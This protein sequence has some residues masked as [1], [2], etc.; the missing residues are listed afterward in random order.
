MRPPIIEITSIWVGLTLKNACTFPRNAP[1]KT[2]DQ[3][4][5]SKNISAANAIPDGGQIGV[6]LPGAI[7][8]NWPNLAKR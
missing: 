5:L 8:T 1:K 3:A 7:A 4:R 6:T 2:P